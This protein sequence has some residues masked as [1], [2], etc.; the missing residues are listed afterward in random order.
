[1]K[2]ILLLSFMFTFAVAFCAMAQR[3]VSGTVRSA[4]DNSA[5]PGVNVVLKGSTTG[6]TTDLDGNYRLSVPEEGG[7]LVFSFIGLTQQEVEIGARSVI[8]VSMQSDVQQLTEVVVTAFGVEREQKSLGYSVSSVDGEEFVKARE[9]NIANSLAGKVAGV[10]VTGSSGSVGSSSRVVIRGNS[11]ING[12]NQPLYVVDGIPISNSNI[13]SVDRFT[14][15]D[16]GNRIQDINPDDVESMSVLKGPAATALY[17]QRAANGAIIITTKKGKKNSKTSVTINSSVRF[18]DP[19]RLPDYQNKYGQGSAGKIDSSATANWG[20]EMLGQSFV[21][22]NGNIDRYSPHPDNVENFYGTGKTIINSVALAGGDEKGTFRMSVTKFDQEGFVPNTNYDRLNASFNATRQFDNKFYSSFGANYIRTRNEGRP[23]TGFNDDGAVASVVGFLPRNY[24]QDSLANYLNADGSPRLFLGLN[25]NP[26]WSLNENVYTGE[27]DRFITFAQVGFKPYDWMDISWK[28]GADVYSERRQQNTAPGS[29]ADPLGEFWANDLF[30][31]NLNSDFFITLN[32]QFTPDL[33]V[34]LLLGHNV[35]EQYIES[36]FNRAQELTDPTLFIADNALINSPENAILSRIRLIGAFF[37]L[38][39]SYKDYLFL[40]VTG[41]NDWNSTLPENSQ[42]FFYPSV[43]TSAIVT[44]MFNLNSEVLN[45]AKV[46]ASYAEVGNGTDPFQLDFLYFP[47]TSIF[48]LFGVDNAYPWNG[49]PGFGGSGNIP[50]LALKP[51]RTSSWEIGTELQFFNSRFLLDATYYSSETT[52]Q[53]VRIDLPGSTGFLTQ[54]LN[55]GTVTNKGIEVLAEVTPVKA[56]DFKWVV[57]G[58]FAKNVNKL[59]DLP[60]NFN[61]IDINGTRTDPGLR[62][63]L[64]RS[65]GTLIGSDWRRDDDGNILINPNTGLRLDIDDQEIGNIT[66]DFIAGLGNEVSWKGLSASVLIDW[67]QGGDI[68]SQTIQDLRAGGHVK[69]TLDRDGAYI[70]KGVI[71][72]EEDAEGNPTSTKPNDIPITYQQLW[73]QEND[74]DSEGVF[75]GTYVKLREIKVSYSLPSS[76]LDKT[77]LGAVQFGFE[78]RNLAILYTKVPHI[79]P[80]VS[81]YGPGNAQ[82]IEAYN[83]PTTRSYGFNV[84]LTF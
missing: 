41:R 63:I 78:A 22:A 15:V 72:L 52:D 9:T 83:L 60:D 49:I 19:L 29:V 53:I 38:G 5:I 1:M 68:H 8:D 69:E 71:L 46:R 54:T 44:D 16:Y 2:R 24:S 66:P 7:V 37:D 76:L 50:P 75:D 40:N 64:N 28:V 17:G 18:D 42:S 32:H 3:T 11:S 13:A 34:N 56:G 39:A 51:E 14:G 81:F 33:N 65:L 30:E 77:P 23:I 25:Q 79:D 26:Y 31:S 67:K 73:G 59:V 70:D 20:P 74:V 47:Q 58:T 43:S 55:A 4:D 12:N 84:R 10:Q 82:G 62:A 6:T 48:Q 45:Y 35:Y 27:I 61:F 36:N 80:E 21:N 57:R